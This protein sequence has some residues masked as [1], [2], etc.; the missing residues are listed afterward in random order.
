MKAS[1]DAPK[2]RIWSTS[3]LSQHNRVILDL[4]GKT[5]SPQTLYRGHARICL[6][7]FSFSFSSSP[8]SSSIKVSLW[9]P[10]PARPGN[11]SLSSPRRGKKLELQPAIRIQHGRIRRMC[12]ISPSVF[13]ARAER[14]GGF[15]H[16][17]VYREEPRSCHDYRA[18]SSQTADFSQ[19]DSFFFFLFFLHFWG[20]F[21]VFLFIFCLFF[22]F[23]FLCVWDIRDKHGRVLQGP[24]PPREKYHF[25]SGAFNFFFCLRVSSHLLRVKRN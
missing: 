19:S 21:V 1:G 15:L 3:P 11:D 8:S 5:R 20:P 16:L 18:P 14:E 4:S 2:G 10:A 6:P 12:K 17:P 7:F 24:T 9:S 22:C 23:A 13:L 25:C